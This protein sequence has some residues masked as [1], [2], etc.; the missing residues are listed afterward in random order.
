MVIRKIKEVAEKISKPYAIKPQI[1]LYKVAQEIDEFRKTFRQ[2]LLTFVTSA[3]GVGA[4]LMWNDTI[5]EALTNITPQGSSLLVKVYSALIITSIAVLATYW[6][7][8]WN[9]KQE[10]V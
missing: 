8:K 9:A 6:L 1:K 10:N 4:A 5:K 3:F 2:S 7:S